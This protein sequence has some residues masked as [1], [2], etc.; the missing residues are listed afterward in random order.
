[1]QQSGRSLQKKRWV[2][3]RISLSSMY[4]GCQLSLSAQSF[5]RQLNI[6][7]LR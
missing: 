1:M 4:S 7:G 5:R 6:S 2:M 3:V